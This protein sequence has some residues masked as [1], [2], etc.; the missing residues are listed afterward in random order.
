[1]CETCVCDH[2]F[3]SPIGVGVFGVILFIAGDGLSYLPRNTGFTTAEP[4]HFAITHFNAFFF[5]GGWVFLGNQEWRSL[6]IVVLGY[7]RL[8]GRQR[9]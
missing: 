3:R 6:L 8:T 4:K 9:H 5:F 7:S 1:M 2:C